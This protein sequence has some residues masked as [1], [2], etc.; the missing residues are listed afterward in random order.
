MLNIAVGIA[1]RF[2]R[3]AITV[4]YASNNERI[5]YPPGD[6]ASPIVHFHSTG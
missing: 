1:N 5:I 3:L 2:D 6:E 4:T